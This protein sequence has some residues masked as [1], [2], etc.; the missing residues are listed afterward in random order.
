MVVPTRK[1]NTGNSIPILGLGVFQTPE[2][3]A[4]PLV[5]KA[6]DDG[7]RLF[8]SAA[9][10]G[11][12]ADVCDGIG[13]WLQEDPAQHKREDIFYTTKIADGH[14]G[15]EKSKKAIEDSLEK[16]K[17]IGYIDLFLIHSPQSDYESRHG[18]WKALQE[19]YESGKVRNIGVSNYG[20][21]HLEEL[22]A[23]P[24]LKVIPAVNQVE[25][26]PW[27]MRDE[28]VDYC[29]KKG[30]TMEAFSPLTRGM[31]LNDPSLVKVAKKHGKNAGQVLINWSV[32]KGFIPLP[33]TATESRLASNLDVLD[34]KLTE[35]D[36]EAIE[37]RGGYKVTW[38]FWDPT[39]Y[40]LD[41]EKKEGEEK[42]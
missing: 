36:L 9:Y 26:H 7:Y 23:Y 3:V 31:W 6:L 34:F 20:I 17:K 40:P 12:E 25:L 35:E 15:Y 16:A 27:L 21:K 18:T 22:F 11:N 1:L 28:L 14:H 39:K 38:G 13:E 41:S 2:H 33:K 29:T 5:H 32:S 42:K 10:Y 4:G 37:H 30:I 19:A 8:D 24:D